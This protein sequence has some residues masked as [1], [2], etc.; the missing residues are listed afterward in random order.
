LQG[1]I[2][3]GIIEQSDAP[4]GAPVHM[5]KKPGSASGYRFCIDF[6]RVNKYVETD[7]FSLPTIQS[8]LDA[9]AGSKFF[10]KFDL[11]SGYWQFPV[12][13]EDR[14][15]LA[16]QALGRRYQYRTVAMGHVQSSFHVQRQMHKIFAE[17][18]GNGILIYIDDIVVYSVTF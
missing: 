7:P 16:F 9:T 8:V 4:S 11:R 14:S 5:V 2:E 3:A 13:E 10:A 17:H 12:A 1:Q 6:T 15:K 18:V